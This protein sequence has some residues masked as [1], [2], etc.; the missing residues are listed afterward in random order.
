[1][2]ASSCA[3]TVFSICSQIQQKTPL[4]CHSHPLPQFLNQTSPQMTAK[5]SVLPQIKEQQ[6]SLN[7]VAAIKLDAKIKNQS[8][9]CGRLQSSAPLQLKHVMSLQQQRLLTLVSCLLQ[10]L[11]YGLQMAI[12]DG[13]QIMQQEDRSPCCM[14]SLGLCN[15]AESCN[16]HAISACDC[17]P[18]AL[19][20][21]IMLS[22]SSCSCSGCY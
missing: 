5:H 15:F 21:S 4:M 1:M 22:L 12:G 8:Q 2:H 13:L 7:P 19:F 16:S 3:Y 11:H 20:K 10:T 14:Q 9:S 18:T 17:T 6:S